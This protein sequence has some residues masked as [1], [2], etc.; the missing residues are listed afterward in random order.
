MLSS[1]QLS[2]T[3]FYYAS[4]YRSFSVSTAMFFQAQLQRA[5]A[6][7]FAASPNQSVEAGTR[8]SGAR[9]LG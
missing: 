2:L 5:V 8:A 4:M 9:L 7:L 6:D 3:Q 1:M